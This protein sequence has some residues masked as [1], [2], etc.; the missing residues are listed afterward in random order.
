MSAA[1]L[2]ATKI[3]PQLVGG[4]HIPFVG[5]EIGQQKNFEVLVGASYH[6]KWVAIPEKLPD[7]NAILP[8]R[9]VAVDAGVETQRPIE[10]TLYARL[11]SKD[12]EG[13]LVKCPRVI[14]MATQGTAGKKENRETL[15][16]LRGRIDA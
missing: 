1:P 2:F 14:P 13:I 4:G 15:G 16:Y 11:H 3:V 7:E 8:A 10:R 9:L 6:F 12:S 5:K